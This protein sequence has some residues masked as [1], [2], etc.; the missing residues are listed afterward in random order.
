M[1]KTDINKLVSTHVYD[2]VQNEVDLIQLARGALID[3][4]FA[5][6]ISIFDND[7]NILMALNMNSKVQRF[8]LN[9][10]LDTQYM[11]LKR[12]LTTERSMLLDSGDM[13][14][15]LKIFKEFHIPNMKKFGLPVD[16]SN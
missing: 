12:D 13:S 4:G 10:F 16:Y 6:L 14:D 1:I 5:P 11:T 15:W 7:K 9:T 8:K 2:R 3:A